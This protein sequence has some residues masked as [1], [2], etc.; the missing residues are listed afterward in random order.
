MYH[1]WELTPNFDPTSPTNRAVTWIRHAGSSAQGMVHNA[2][3]TLERA[4]SPSDL[5]SSEACATSAAT[6]LYSKPDL[7]KKFYPCFSGL[8]LG[9]VH[10]FSVFLRMGI[11]VRHRGGCNYRILRYTTKRL[12]V[13]NLKTRSE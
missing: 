7:P 11:L 5:L 12:S 13:P 6:E 1:Q 8:R 3:I 10:C 9:M 2:H 4:G